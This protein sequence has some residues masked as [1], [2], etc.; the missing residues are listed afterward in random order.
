MDEAA[1]GVNNLRVV[2]VPLDKNV[3]RKPRGFRA[4]A[5]HIEVS[6]LFGA[7]SNQRKRDGYSYAADRL[8]TE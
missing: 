8:T 5:K 7:T 3:D 2:A 1:E 4:G 6:V